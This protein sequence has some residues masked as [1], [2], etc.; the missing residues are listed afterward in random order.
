MKKNIIIT[1]VLIGA[2][3]QLKQIIKI[4]HEHNIVKNP[5]WSGAKQLA[6]HKGSRGF[7]LGGFY[8]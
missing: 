8:S 1:Q 6:F 4:D 3:N 7:E 2:S 5:S